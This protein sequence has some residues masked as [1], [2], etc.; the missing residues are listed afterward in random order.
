MLFIFISVVLDITEKIDEFKESAATFYQIATE[1][2]LNFIPFIIIA[3]SPLF[4]FLATIFFT[5]K[6]AN[7]SEIIPIL[8]GGMSFRRLTLPYFISSCLLYVFLLF[9]NHWLVPMANKNRVEFENTYLRS[10]FINTNRN[11]H[12][13]LNDSSYVYIETY[14]S[15]DSAGFK[16]AY[17]II[18]NRQLVYKLKAFK[19]DWS[20]KDNNWLASNY[21][22]KRISNMREVL[23][24]G[25]K[26]L[27]NLSLK[28]EDFGRRSNFKSTMTTFDLNKF[29]D[30]QKA[31]GV[32]K[33]IYYEVEKYKRYS[34]SFSVF[35]LVLLGMSIGVKRVRGGMGTHIAFGIA[36]SAFYI[37][38]LQFS[39]TFSTNA[40][41]PAYIGTWIPNIIF[42]VFG[43][44][45]YRR[46]DT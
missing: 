38:L 27:L 28:P 3:L 33:L 8:N 17:E 11:I 15:V 41:L 9:C 26:K 25:N 6:M 29:I 35:I 20:A 5:S 13:Q 23:N 10:P 45:L 34:D 7:N 16:F 18:K 31:K 32:D 43:I 22:E 12:R 40:N 21:Q 19:V 46:A 4:I 39:T 42:L 1:Y 30:E 36:L 24:H 37:L 2:Y 14:N 44:L